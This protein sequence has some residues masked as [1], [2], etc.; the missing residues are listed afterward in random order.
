M[1]V[2]I[3]LNSPFVITKQVAPAIYTSTV[4]DSTTFKAGSTGIATNY[5]LALHCS[6]GSLMYNVT[7][8]VCTTANGNVVYAGDV[9]T[10]Q[11]KRTA[12]NPTSMCSLFGL[13]TTTVYQAWVLE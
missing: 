8:A 1:A 13:S 9:H 6:T 11:V 10:F 4:A 7:G 3:L 2:N 5:V 12:T